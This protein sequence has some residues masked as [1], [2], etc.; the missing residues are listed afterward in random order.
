VL[1]FECDKFGILFFVFLY[2]FRTLNPD[3]LGRLFLNR[4]R[5]SNM[6]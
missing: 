5:G 1:A 2:G 6:R 4:L 3:L